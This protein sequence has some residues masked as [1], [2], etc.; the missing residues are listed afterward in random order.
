M[1]LWSD[2]FSV[3]AR[4]ARIK[5][6]AFFRAFNFELFLVRLS[7]CVCVCVCACVRVCV[8]EFLLD[9]QTRGFFIS[10]GSSR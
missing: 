7:F 2:L 5:A 4:G 9:G 8:C 1:R 10:R 3:G 6:A